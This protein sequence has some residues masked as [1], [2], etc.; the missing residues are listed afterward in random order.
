MPTLISYNT[1]YVTD[2]HSSQFNPFM[3]E[4]SSILKK[5]VQIYNSTHKDTEQINLKYKSDIDPQ[6]K[7]DIEKLKTD[8]NIGENLDFLRKTMAETSTNYLS[9]FIEQKKPDFIALIEQTIHVGENNH[10]FYDYF[11]G[12]QNKFDLTAKNINNEDFGILK[13][14]KALNFEDLDENGN[15]NTSSNY[16]IVYDNIVNKTAKNAEG[17]AIAFKKTLFNKQLKWNTNDHPSRKELLN[18]QAWKDLNG[19]IVSYFS[20][21]LG[22]IVC[23]ED[24]NAENKVIRYATGRDSKESIPIIDAGRPIIMTGGYSDED[25]FLKLLV[26]IHGPNIPNLFPVDTVKLC[27]AVRI[28]PLN[29]LQIA[30]VVIAIFIS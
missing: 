2:C 21:D 4:S 14:I 6:I 7:I 3:S 16:F 17:I 28:C 20:A 23:Y 24:P 9:N 12:D 29:E 8:T 26:A 5:A 19:N 18:D 22:P 13:R 1:S 15:N 27:V 30:F 11:M 25:K 10:A